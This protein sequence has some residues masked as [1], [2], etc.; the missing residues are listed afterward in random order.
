[1]IPFR[2]FEALVA[3]VKG[4]RDRVTQDHMEFLDFYQK[5]VSILPD[6]M[7]REFGRIDAPYVK[8]SKTHGGQLELT[9][10][11]LMWWSTIFEEGGRF[12]DGTSVVQR[13]IWDHLNSAIRKGALSDEQK[14]YL[15]KL[16]RGE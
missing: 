13:N 14:L 10:T 3:F 4:D 1:M 8:G 15:L 16:A 12:R 6:D 7:A 9:V 2:A 5:L 11:D